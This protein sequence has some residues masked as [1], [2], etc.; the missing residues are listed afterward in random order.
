MV[1]GTTNGTVTDLDG[2][3]VIQASPGDIL[4]ISY[5]GYNPLQIKAGT[6]TF[7]SIKMTEDT[8]NLE[9]IVVVGYGTQKKSDLISAITSVRGKE[10]AEQ[11]VPR[12]DQLLRGR[13]A[14]CRSFSQ[15]EHREPHRVSVSVAATHFPL[16]TNRFM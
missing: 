16:A 4:E 5:I 2:K 7:L 11:P 3:F 10:L 13:V 12:V 6:Q 9:E 14:G 15:T 1:K 8:Q